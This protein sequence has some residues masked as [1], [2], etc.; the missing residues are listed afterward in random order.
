[1]SNGKVDVRVTQKTGKARLRFYGVAPDQLQVILLA[2]AQARKELG[3]EH[4]TVALE[5]V[6][7]GY[8]GS[9]YAAKLAAP[10]APSA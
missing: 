2:L 10:G 3:T 7:A 6:M 8:L 1:M 4:D 5:N 9:L